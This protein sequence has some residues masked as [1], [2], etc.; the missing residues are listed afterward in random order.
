MYQSI[1]C[2]VAKAAPPHRF[3]F[4]SYSTLE[5][6]PFFKT[7]SQKGLRGKRQHEMAENDT[8]TKGNEN[9]LSFMCTL[10]DKSQIHIL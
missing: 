1:S 5:N 9:F 4:A 2:I 3:A 10:D 6:W 8:V 7:L